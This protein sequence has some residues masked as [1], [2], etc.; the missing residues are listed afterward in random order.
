MSTKNKRRY[1]PA[2]FREDAVRYHLNSGK[3]IKVSA[4]NLGISHHNLARWISKFKNESMSPVE[5]D[6]HK[7]N[8]R[9]RKE[10]ANARMEADIL[11]KAV[12]VFTK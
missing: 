7:E 10:L 8:E 6:L 4:D 12:A 11:K 1:Y 3:T 5:L 9:L 2:E